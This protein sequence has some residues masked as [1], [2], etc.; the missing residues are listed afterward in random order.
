MKKIITKTSIITGLLLPLSAFAY[1]NNLKDLIDLA[2]QY[3][4]YGIYFI[5]GL[6]I[7]LFVY[8]VFKYFI[9]SGDD[10]GAKKEAGLYVMYSAIGFFVILSI[11]GLVNI[12]M[13]TFNL[14]TAQ[15]ATP[16]GTYTSSSGTSGVFSNQNS[17][18]TN[19]SSNSSGTNSSTKSSG[20]NYSDTYYGN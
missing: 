9:M 3:F 11:W 1:T 15:P 4:K 10:A 12:L 8:N 14:N 16:F 17:S 19:S 18:G 7:V 5:L 6:A 20:N 2:I 13:N